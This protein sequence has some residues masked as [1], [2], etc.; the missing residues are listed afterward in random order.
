M[1]FAEIKIDTWRE[2]LEAQ[3]DGHLSTDTLATLIDDEVPSALLDVIQRHLQSCAE[4]RLAL[5]DQL[6]ATGAVSSHPWYTAVKRAEEW[7]QLAAAGREA[8]RIARDQLHSRG[9]NPVFSQNGVLMEE[10]ADGSVRPRQRK[11][12]TAA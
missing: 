2:Q 1:A 8:T 3:P 12:D 11:I 6:S 9:I 7:A 4:C 10:L 5:R